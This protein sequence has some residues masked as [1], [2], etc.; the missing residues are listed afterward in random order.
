MCFCCSCRGIRANL[1]SQVGEGLGQVVV[2]ITKVAAN[3]GCHR[4]KYLSQSCQ[5]AAPG[6]SEDTH[7]LTHYVTVLS[8]L[9]FISLDIMNVFLSKHIL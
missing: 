5:Q 2:K 7:T 3:V 4:D 6:H 8:V 1:Q 9:F